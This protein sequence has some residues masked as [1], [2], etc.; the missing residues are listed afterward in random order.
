MVMTEEQEE[1]KESE[2]KKG[3]GIVASRGPDFLQE[4]LKKRPRL[5]IV[6]FIL[7]CLGAS[8]ALARM[9]YMI[10]DHFWL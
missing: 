4:F 1:S 2:E 7:V 8:A 3:Q 5:T 9:I 10:I 6:L